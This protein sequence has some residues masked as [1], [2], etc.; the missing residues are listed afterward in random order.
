MTLAE[1]LKS[2]LMKSLYED[3]NEA[4]GEPLSAIAKDIDKKN[5]DASGRK[6]HIAGGKEGVET[7]DA[8][9]SDTK[10]KAGSEG[11]KIGKPTFSDDALKSTEKQPDKR[12]LAYVRAQQNL[13]KSGAVKTHKMGES[14]ELTEEETAVAEELISE[15]AF[16]KPVKMGSST[17]QVHTAGKGELEI[18][19]NGTPFAKIKHDANWKRNSASMIAAHNARLPE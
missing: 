6:V 13:K 15:M 7:V 1:Q 3:V 10:V 8:G 5:A 18:H 4:W 11:E 16:D 17:Y 19:H 12:T 2:K 14:V 9:D